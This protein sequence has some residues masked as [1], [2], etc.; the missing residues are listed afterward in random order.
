M[1]TGSL[2][3]LNGRPET[4][5]DLADRGFQFG[6][7]VFTTLLIQDGI[8]LFAREHLDRLD[9][10]AKIL[11][12]PSPDRGILSTEIDHLASACPSGILKIHWTRGS[13]GR[14]YLPPEN[15]SPTRAL[16]LREA[17][18]ESEKLPAPL[19]LR[20]A[21]MRLGINPLLAGAKHMNRLEQVLARLEWRDP[22]IDESLLLDSE[23]FV[24]EGVSTNVFLLKGA[25]VL[26]PLLDRAGVRGVTR[27][28]L[29]KMASASGYEVREERVSPQTVLGADALLLT[30]SVRGICPVAS[31]EG[32]SY[33]SQPFAEQMHASYLLELARTRREWL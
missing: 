18:P 12:L 10:D 19:K 27:D 1:V 7:G 29:I 20:W 25:T 31:L 5:V 24:V 4:M 16:I 3:L 6:D 8:P 21:E 22:E 15:L 17:D 28:L 33:V 11:K 26:T 32:R 14:G 30:N 2:T 23:G 13:G 9:R